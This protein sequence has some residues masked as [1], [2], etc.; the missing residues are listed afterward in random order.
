MISAHVRFVTSVLSGRTC[1][2]QARGSTR[3]STTLNLKAR[4]VNTS[5][6]P[7]RIQLCD[8]SDAGST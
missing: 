2:L 4:T 5:L 1:A 7:S 6:I 3:K 8:A